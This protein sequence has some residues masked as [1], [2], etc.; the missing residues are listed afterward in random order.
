MSQ[1][2]AISLEDLEIK[3]YLITKLKNA[4]IQSIFDLAV[5]IPLD[6]LEYCPEGVALEKTCRQYQYHKSS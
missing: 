1:H 5:S 2:A 6:L 3:P 4:G